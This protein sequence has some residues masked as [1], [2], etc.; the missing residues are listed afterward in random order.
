[1][2][3]GPG[4][5]EAFGKRGKSVNKHDDSSQTEDGEFSPRGGIQDPDQMPSENFQAVWRGDPRGYSASAG[6]EV[7]SVAKGRGYQGGRE[8][9]DGG[10]VHGAGA[11][12][13]SGPGNR[14]RTREW[15]EE[16][17]SG[18]ED[19]GMLSQ[20]HKASDPAGKAKPSRTDVKPKQ[21][22]AFTHVADASAHG[23]ADITQVRNSIRST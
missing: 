10:H 18:V 13:R 2:A 9:K 22:S 6:D 21:L 19:V 20:G 5:F 17:S 4:G 8:Q 14:G 3:R 12:W 15:V 16:H 11:V 7:D 23:S 1:M